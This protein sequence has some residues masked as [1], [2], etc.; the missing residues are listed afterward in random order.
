MFIFMNSMSGMKP[1][2]IGSKTR[3]PGLIL[4][5]PCIHFRGH[6]LNAIFITLCQDVYLSF[7]YKLGPKLGH[8]RLKS[9]S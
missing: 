7:I 3:S 5:K 4:E 9:M 6:S 2:H 1:G 8:V